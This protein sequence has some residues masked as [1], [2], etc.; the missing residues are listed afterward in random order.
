MGFG[1]GDLVHVVTHPKDTIDQLVDKGKALTT[2]TNEFEA[3]LESTW[4]NMANGLLSSSV[5]VKPSNP[6][7]GVIVSMVA[8]LEAGIVPSPVLYGTTDC[9]GISFPAALDPFT[10][11]KA[12]KREDVCKGDDF[13]TCPTG[14]VQL[15]VVPPGVEVVFKSRTT[16]HIREQ[17]ELVLN[18]QKLTHNI[19]R[20]N[21][22]AGASLK[23][24]SA[25]NNGGACLHD[26]PL[27][28][29]TKDGS[30]GGGVF[31]VKEYDATT[32]KFYRTINSCGGPFWPSFGNFK[33]PNAQDRQSKTWRRCNSDNT[34]NA[35]VHNGVTVVTV[36]DAFDYCRPKGA[37]KSAVTPGAHQISVPEDPRGTRVIEDRLHDRA[38]FPVYGRQKFGP[39]KDNGN[40]PPMGFTACDCAGSDAAQVCAFS[41]CQPADQIDG[42]VDSIE[43]RQAA[44][45][46]YQQARSCLGLDPLTMG[47][48][49]LQRW[50]MGSS[51]CDELMANVCRDPR[52]SDKPEITKGCACQV[53]AAALAALFQ[54][55]A[56]PV[57]CFVDICTSKDPY[58]YRTHRQQNGCSS[59]VCQQSLQLSGD[60]LF[61]T[62]YQ[63]VTCNAGVYD[64][65]TR[66]QMNVPGTVAEPPAPAGTLAADREQLESRTMGIHL[67]LTP[68]FWVAIA[69]L[70]M[71]LVLLAVSGIRYWRGGSSDASTLPTN[72]NR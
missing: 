26:V 64:V 69:L 49:V 53:E 43:F 16:A 18:H 55:D 5:A 11:N 14:I 13:A 66:R 65:Q 27:P 39:N 34:L 71:G 41:N 1:I 62:G 33:K 67:T 31:T 21:E 52:Y 44:D 6:C 70:S 45:W 68:F 10:R 38:Y 36:G 56:V 28:T 60:A 50:R 42:S 9:N 19:W 29:D 40:P 32:K 46:E 63:Q 2:D 4:S 37:E 30:G 17:G 23:W 22:S 3:Q 58:V 59:T 35:D 47:G 25:E 8:A 24:G 51:T 7:Y 12:Y 61:S 54:D 20:L 48:V 57:S 15:M 72:P